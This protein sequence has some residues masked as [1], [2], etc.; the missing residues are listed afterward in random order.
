MSPDGA[1]WWDGQKWQ[2]MPNRA[3]EPAVAKA[4]PRAKP[5]S[6]QTTA[7]LASVAAIALML[8][9]GGAWAWLQSVQ[10]Q[11]P[12]ATP[13]VTYAPDA[14]LTANIGTDYCP[15]AHPGD[16]SCWK[17]TVTNSGPAIGKLAIMFVSGGP[18]T[19]WLANHPNGVLSRNQSTKGCQLQAEH[20]RIVCG[21]VAQNGQVVAY[22]LGNVSVIGTYHYAVKFADISSG[23]MINQRADGTHA[24]APWSETTS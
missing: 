24:V 1:Y 21:S 18:Y 20:K 17:G 6:V 19:D 23:S 9:G 11:S 5:P 14:P 12:P 2:L 15:V 8:V 7:M 10:S 13:Q 3:P 22:M 4:A 16:T